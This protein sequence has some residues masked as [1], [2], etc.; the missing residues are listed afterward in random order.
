MDFD[1]LLSDDNR[2]KL[3]LLQY[4]DARKHTTTT[5]KALEAYLKCSK[6]KIDKYLAELQ[7]ELLS[8]T[9][10][11]PKLSVNPSGEVVVERL[12][13][14]LIKMIRL[15]YFQESQEFKLLDGILNQQITTEEFAEKTNVSISRAFV[16]KKNLTQFLK[17]MNITI[18]KNSLKGDEREIRNMLFTMYYEV[19]NGISL[20]F[21]AEKNES[22][23]KIVH[24]LEHI[25]NLKLSYTKQIKLKLMLY[26]VTSRA[27]SGDFIETCYFNESSE[28]E[29]E[30]K[31]VTGG[32]KRMF[33]IEM[34]AAGKM[35]R[36][37]VG[38]VLLFLYLEEEEFQIDN[39]IFSDAA[40]ARQDENSE[41]MTEAI[42]DGIVFAP[43][44]NLSER[45]QTQRLLSKR[46]NMIHHKRSV[47]DFRISGFNSKDQIGFFKETYPV[48]FQAV[49]NAMPFLERRIV[50]A[51]DSVH[52]RLFYDY[53][54]ALIECCPIY[55]V[56]QPIYVYIDF[57]YGQDYNSFI[58]NQVNNYKNLNIV[59]ESRYTNHT[60]IYISDCFVQSVTSKQIIWKSL[61][62][63]EDW[64]DFGDKIIQL[65]QEKYR[66]PLAN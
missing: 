41:I 47:F 52:V 9:E 63:A 48:F 12:S 58:A 61:P 64:Q 37:E 42:L 54:L 13:P 53:L 55:F 28:T 16:E 24:F 46:L 22:L 51:D 3:H 26:I 4:L 18:K 45:E 30:I 49:D 65:K 21:D 20:P 66:R 35:V 56:E 33:P 44:V 5:A 6:F 29:Y 17:K 34:D 2:N 57:S 39:A 62:T 59:L 50:V 27:I 38:Y 8:Y 19:Y 40:F 43:T 15:S 1:E 11:S 31:N 60:M 10:A 23:N 32:L 14:F 7:C 25:Y 36:N